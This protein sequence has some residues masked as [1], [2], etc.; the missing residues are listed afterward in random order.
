MLFGK[1]DVVFSLP[2]WQ[3]QIVGDLLL[4]LLL[5]P[6]YQYEM[7]IK[8]IVLSI[9]GITCVVTDFCWFMGYNLQLSRHTENKLHKKCSR[10]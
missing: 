3:F 6:I 7:M 5:K 9:Q 10:F 8:T 4:L 2:K 1:L